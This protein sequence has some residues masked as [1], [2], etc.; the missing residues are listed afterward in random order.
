MLIMIS[1]AVVSPAK[2]LIPAVRPLLCATLQDI[3]HIVSRVFPHAEHGLKRKREQGSELH[4]PY[5]DAGLAFFH[6]PITEESTYILA[7]HLPTS[8]ANQSGI[9]S[10]CCTVCL[11]V[12]FQVCL[13]LCPRMI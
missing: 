4:S 10:N 13:A 8:F 11:R 9:R 7:V 12:Y 5:S 1:R 6:F 3:L 2:A